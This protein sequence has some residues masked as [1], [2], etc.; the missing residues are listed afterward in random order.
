MVATLPTPG[1][2]NVGWVI[3]D[4]DELSS[5][6]SI[7]VEVETFREE[8]LHFD[9]RAPFTYGPSR[10]IVRRSSYYGMIDEIELDGPLTFHHVQH[11]SD[12]IVQ[13]VGSVGGKPWIIARLLDTMSRDL[14]STTLQGVKTCPNTLTTR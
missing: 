5:D 14:T 11:P 12:A 1:P 2:S 13:L 9:P 10:T 4:Y 7:F 6:L 8:E 3:E